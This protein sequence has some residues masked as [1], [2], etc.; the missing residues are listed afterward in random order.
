MTES[1]KIS[2]VSEREF[3]E[4]IA[5]EIPVAKAA[6]LVV[7]RMRYGEC[8]C[9]LP[10]DPTHLRPGGTVSGPAMMMVADVVMFG[11]VLSVLGPVKQAV[12]TN[13]NINFLRR[14]GPEALVVE[15]DAIKIGKRL[16]VLEVT[17]F[18]ENDHDPVAHATGTY[19]IPTATPAP[20]SP[21]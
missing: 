21:S 5:Q 17:L 3:A 19:S 20:P 6:G 7:R 4:I 10:F 14:P 18:S 9:A 2:R 1:K 13:F 11:V 15:G 8:V 16:A 12:T